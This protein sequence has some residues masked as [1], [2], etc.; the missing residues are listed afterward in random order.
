MEITEKLVQ[1]IA[2]LARLS[3]SPEEKA[4]VQGH[5][6]KILRYVE[7][8]DPVDTKGIDPSIFPLEVC[9]I[10]AK[11]ESRP[12]LPVGEAVANAPARREG[13]FLVPRII[14]AAPGTPADLEED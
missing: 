13:F 7:S 8:L 14:A 11:D 2:T 4:E 6:E 12:S 5:F 1:H 9:N 3:L 10:F